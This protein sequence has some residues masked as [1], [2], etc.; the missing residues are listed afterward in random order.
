MRGGEGRG[1][2]AWRGVGVRRAQFTREER[3]RQG[4]DPWEF[5]FLLSEPS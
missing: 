2:G 3:G 1:S 5:F 4:S